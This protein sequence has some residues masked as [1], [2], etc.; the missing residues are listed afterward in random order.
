MLRKWRALHV[1]MMLAIV[2]PLG[3]S[4]APAVAQDADDGTPES[5]SEIQFTA[6]PD[7]G[8][9]GEPFIAQLE[10]GG[11][12]TFTLVLSNQ[13]A[14]TMGLS[15]YTGNTY[16]ALNGGLTLGPLGEELVSPA[17]WLGF[18]PFSVDLQPDEEQTSTFT[19]SVPEGT[20]P[21]EYVAAIA[22]ET[23]DAYAVEGSS[24]FLQK[25]RKVLAVYIVVP[26]D[27]ES[28][29]TL[30]TPIAQLTS[31]GVGVRLR[32]PVVNTGNVRVILGGELVLFDKSGVQLA[33]A[34]IQMRAVYGGHQTFVEVGL[35]TAPPA[36]EYLLSLDLKDQLSEATA[37]LDK[38]PVVIPDASAAQFDVSMTSGT[39]TPGGDP[40]QFASIAVTLNNQGATIQSSRL[41]VSVS[42]N[43]ELVEDFVLA[44]SL[45]I[46][47]GEITVEQRYI[48]LAG[49]E[50]GTWTFSLK[51]EVIDAASGLATP[52]L[53]Q[54][55]FATLEVP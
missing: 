47:T 38:A 2:V 6:R 27:F 33:N 16:S 15:V 50:S 28:S 43:G 25:V 40:I 32:V 4:G 54:E 31:T 52:I 14:S 39:V 24:T 41:T 55:N 42:R 7:S 3:I 29:F 8:L 30:G 21:G 11:S 22:V 23:V 17:T 53:T 18:S 12:T 19:V 46:P 44:N 36:G 10:P 9:D 48:P 20:A 51:L 37:S 5:L 13:S 45:A 49:F 34:T 26:G 35:P 1:F